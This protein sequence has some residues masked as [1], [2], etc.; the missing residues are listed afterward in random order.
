[1]AQLKISTGKKLDILSGTLTNLGPKIVVSGVDASSTVT[2]TLSGN[3]TTATANSS[4]VAIITIPTNTNFYGTWT[5]SGTKNSSA[6][7][8]TLIVDRYKKYSVTFS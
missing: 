4:G 1:M 5:I 6:V 2:A 7:S 3:S 8:D